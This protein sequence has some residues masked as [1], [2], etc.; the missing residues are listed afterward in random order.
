MLDSSLFKNSIISDKNLIQHTHKNNGC[1][2]EIVLF[3][4][5]CIFILSSVIHIQ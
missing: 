4:I 1:Q 2:N 5:W 3:R